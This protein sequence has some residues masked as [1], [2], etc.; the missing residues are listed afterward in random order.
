MDITHLDHLVLTVIHIETSVAFYQRVLG[1]EPEIFGNNRVALHFG[2]QKINLHQT[3]RTFEPHAQYLTPGSADLCLVTGTPLP[4][5][6]QYV[7]NCGVKIEAGPV[8]RTGAMGPMT[9]FYF[10]DPDLNL[11]EVCRY[12][13]VYHY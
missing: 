9:S 6:M 10:R 2:K 8:G 13:E 12:H 11:I 3:N 5:A 7:R 1:M 4:E